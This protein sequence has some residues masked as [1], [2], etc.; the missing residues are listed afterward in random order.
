MATDAAPTTGGADGTPAPDVLRIQQDDLEARPFPA[1]E[2][3]YRVVLQAAA[4]R[5]ILAHA[6]S[7]PEVELCGV[8]VGDLYRD[9]GPYLVITDVIPGRAAKQGDTSVTFTHS[10]W[11]QIHREMDARHA[12]RRIVGWYH[13]H[14]GFGVFL[15][16]V[17]LF[18]H[19]NFFNAAWQVALVVDPKADQVGLF[20]WEDGA[21]VRARRFWVG[22]E[23]RWEADRPAV[24]AAPARAARAAHEPAARREREGEGEARPGD[25][26]GGLLSSTVLLAVLGVLILVLAYLNIRRDFENARLA[27]ELQ[28]VRRQAASE[29]SA[30]ARSLAFRLRDRLDRGEPKDE[31][32]RAMFDEV[33]RLDPPNATTYATLLPE[34]APPAGPSRADERKAGGG[35]SRSEGAGR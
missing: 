27:T 23:V 7:S 6:R 18:A 31:R 19:R 14:P 9:D 20:F 25:V 21:I 33:I 11:E 10:T 28:G 12:G 32:M 30:L 1:R 34:L 15:S 4:H 2:S 16:E 26:E 8:L 29:S 24:S 3:E 17:D 35:A 5:A 22:E 13:T